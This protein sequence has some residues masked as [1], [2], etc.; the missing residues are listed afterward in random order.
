MSALKKHKP[1]NVIIGAYCTANDSKDHQ[2]F[3]FA[4]RHIYKEAEPIIRV[5][6]PVERMVSSEKPSILRDLKVTLINQKNFGFFLGSML[7]AVNSD[8]PERL[9]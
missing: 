5:L 8:K 1:G 7:E 4:D 9:N 6:F 3:A 2:I